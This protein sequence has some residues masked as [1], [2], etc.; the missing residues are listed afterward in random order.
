MQIVHDAARAGEVGR[1]IALLYEALYCD[2]D[3]AE[4]REI[5]GQKK[6][7]GR[8][9]SSEAADRLMRGQKWS[10]RFGWLPA[11]HLNRYQQGERF[12]RGKWISALEDSHQHKELRNGW[13][14]ETDHYQVT[15]NLGLEAGVELAQKLEAF[16][17]VWS[18][19]FAGYYL[20][21]ESVGE[22]FKKINACGKGNQKT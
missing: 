1:A 20:S 17:S 5:L 15:T 13:K 9:V 11:N 3:L 12:F 10:E 19:L 16:Y 18:Q 7:S 14:I 4:G 21:G 2:G 22:N 8:W 6:I